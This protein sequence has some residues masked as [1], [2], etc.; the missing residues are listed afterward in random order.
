[1]TKRI[2]STLI[3]WGVGLLLLEVV[4]PQ[5]AVG[6]LTPKFAYVANNTGNNVS[7]YTIDATT[8]ALTPISGSPFAAGLAPHGVAVDPSGK[9]AY[10]TNGNGN[11]VSAYTIAA[12]IGALTPVSGSPFA[13][14]SVPRGVAVAPSGKF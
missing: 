11:N 9:F 12:T 1:M 13:A 4:A 3:G 5:A 14:G 6:L 10:V 8:G 2:V 7:A